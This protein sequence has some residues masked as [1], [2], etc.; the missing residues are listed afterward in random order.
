M[1]PFKF[2][3]YDIKVEGVI[4]PSTDCVKFTFSNGVDDNSYFLKLNTPDDKKWHNVVNK[5]KRSIND[6]IRYLKQTTN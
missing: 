2:K 6:R 3:G 1:I 4:T 5:I